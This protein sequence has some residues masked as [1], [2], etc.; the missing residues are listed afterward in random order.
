MKAMW[1]FDDSLVKAIASADAEVEKSFRDVEAAV[2]CFHR[3]YYES[4]YEIPML[5]RIEKDGGSLLDVF[6][7]QLL[8]FHVLQSRRI[9]EHLADLICEFNQRR[10]LACSLTLRAV[11]EVIAAINYYVAE[12]E[13]TLPNGPLSADVCEEFIRLLDMMNRGS[14]FDWSRWALEGEER[15]CLQKGYESW[16]QSGR[17]TKAPTPEFEQ[18]NVMTM[19][20][21]LARA[22]GNRPEIGQGRIHLWY[23]KLS[24]MCHPALGAT[25]IALLNE[26]EEDSYVIKP[27]VS[28]A[29][30]TWY[31]YEIIQPMLPALTDFARERL[32][33]IIKIGG[34]FSRGGKGDIT[35]IDEAD[36]R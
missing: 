16:F 32:D 17:K 18:I 22:V 31:W 29:L 6:Q 19:I 26:G 30:M 35:D 28:D 27:G 34:K 12:V 23:A 14:R 3:D 20:D 1:R 4:S 10:L 8:L 15:Q 13:K 25:I 2:D 5:E 21:R 36:G 33:E 11:L 24:D 7:S 9:A